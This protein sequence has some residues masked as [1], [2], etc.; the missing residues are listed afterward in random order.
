MTFATQP[1][2]P[3]GVKVP[4]ARHG[5]QQLPIP[6]AGTAEEA[7][8]VEFRNRLLAAC[9]AQLAA[10]GVAFRATH[11]EAGKTREA[12]RREQHAALGIIPRAQEAQPVEP[13]AAGL[14]AGD[15]P[16]AKM[17]SAADETR[18]G[19]GLPMESAAPVSA[20]AAGSTVLADRM[21]ARHGLPAA[22]TGPVPAPAAVTAT[23]ADRMR[24]R[25]GLPA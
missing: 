6:V 16:I 3:W 17:L 1:T 12:A 19:H 5:A 15:A 23:L 14:G 8:S 7:R 4:A 10:N 2:N 20:P 18:P 22:S 24:A 25:H 13:H 21:R 9:S 11:G